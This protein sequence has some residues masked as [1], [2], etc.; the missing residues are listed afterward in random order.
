[1][2]PSKVATIYAR[3]ESGAILARARVN[4]LSGSHVEAVKRSLLEQVGTMVLRRQIAPRDVDIDDSEVAEKRKSE[5]T[6]ASKYAL[7][8]AVGD[9]IFLYECAVRYGEHYTDHC[10]STILSLSYDRPRV[11]GNIVAS[12]AVA[13]AAEE[14]AAPTQGFISKTAAK[15]AKF[16]WGTA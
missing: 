13:D 11:V 7:D 14:A 2:K 8:S 1:M 3:D 15:I 5:G 12:A 4:N 10:A 16:L 9:P 6:A